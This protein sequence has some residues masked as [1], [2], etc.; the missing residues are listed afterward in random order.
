MAADTKIF[1]VL[2]TG[3]TGIIGRALVPQ[4][5]SEGFHVIALAGGSGHRSVIHNL[6]HERLTLLEG[7][8]EE[9]LVSAVA[10]FQES[11]GDSAAIHLAGKAD[12]GW[13]AF[14]IEETYEANVA[15]TMT[16]L[17][18]C[19]QAQV[20]RFLFPSSALVYGSNL[21]HAVSEQDIPE[22][23]LWYGATKLAAETII[24]GIAA[25]SAMQA[26]ILRLPNVYGPQSPPKT[27]IGRLI[28]QS[29]AKQPLQV[30]DKTPVRDFIYIDDVASGLIKTMCAPATSPSRT[31]NLST[32]RATQIGNLVALAQAIVD[33]RDAELSEEI[34]EIS[35]KLVLKNDLF[36]EEIGWQPEISLKE[37]LTRILTRC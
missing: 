19:L 29:A 27:V 18:A 20:S 37:G 7:G 35:T 21:P 30:A 25:T 26:D 9:I 17:E 2:V 28:Q 22:P 33:G 13:C 5:L 12:A 36:I 11:T 1:H 8:F 3:A 4:L 34:G 32:G 10:I 31:L 23:D 14:N 16:V 6:E 15:L 24:R